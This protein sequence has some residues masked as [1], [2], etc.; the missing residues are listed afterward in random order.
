MAWY[1]G[2]SESKTHEVGLLAPNELGLY[3]MSGNVWEWCQDFFGNYSAE[4]QNN[5]TGPT[6]GSYKVA[7]GGSFFYEA[8]FCRVSFRNFWPEGETRSDIGLRLALSLTH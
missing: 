5:P 8:N 3:D 2:N 7:R 4:S 1:L 6:D